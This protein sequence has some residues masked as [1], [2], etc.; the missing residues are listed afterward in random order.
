VDVNFSDPD[1]TTYTTYAMNTLRPVA[2]NTLPRVLTGHNGRVL[3][4]DVAET[5]LTAAERDRCI[6]QL[7]IGR[8][9]P[10]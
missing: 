8:C 4:R 3:R 10:S 9:S 5:D 7:D 6:Q 2:M 1:L